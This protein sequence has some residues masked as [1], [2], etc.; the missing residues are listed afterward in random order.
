MIRIDIKNLY[1][2]LNSFKKKKYF[3]IFRT[4]Y[5]GDKMTNSIVTKIN[6]VVRLSL[7]IG[8]CLVFS[9]ALLANEVNPPQKLPEKEITCDEL[10]YKSILNSHWIYYESQYK[11]VDSFHIAVDE[12]ILGTEEI[13]LNYVSKDCSSND[14][15]S[16][17]LCKFYFKVYRVLPNKTISDTQEDLTLDF[18]QNKILRSK[19]ENGNVNRSELSLPQSCAHLSAEYIEREN[20]LIKR[21]SNLQKKK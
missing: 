14:S 11:G 6:T 20:Q 17:Q 7:I 4:N 1:R 13:Y 2:F 21:A 19:F 3:F 16:N 10:S 12:T 5:K 18:T 9:K 8:H 15:G